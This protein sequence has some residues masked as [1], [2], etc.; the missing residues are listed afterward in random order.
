M[1][2]QQTAMDTNSLDVWAPQ[3]SI[4][5]VKMQMEARFR[6]ISPKLF[7]IF[8]KVIRCSKATKLIVTSK[9]C[10]LKTA[11]FLSIKLSLNKP[12]IT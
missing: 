9:S 6:P 12:K 1:G 4:L 5:E 10:K 2:K 11:E 8:Q 3:G 7:K